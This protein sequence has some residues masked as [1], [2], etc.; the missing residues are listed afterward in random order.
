MLGKLTIFFL[1]AKLNCWFFCHKELGDPLAGPGR[2]GAGWAGTPPRGWDCLAGAGCGGRGRAGAAGRMQGEIICIGDELI[3]GQVGDQNARYAASRFT[4]LGI[5]LRAISLVRDDP[6]AIG[7]ALARGLG[8]SDFLLV[9]GGLGATDDD[10]TSAAAARALGL[11][12]GESAAMLA[13]LAAAWGPGTKPPHRGPQDGSLLPAGAES[14][15]RAARA[16]AWR[17]RWRPVYLMP[18]VPAEM[19]GLLDRAVLPRLLARQPAGG[20]VATRELR[21][22]GLGESEIQDR[23]AGL[24]DS[25]AGIGYY[26]EGVE[27]RL[28]LMG[29]GPD[30]SAAEGRVDRLAAEVGR[31]LAGLVVAED[32]ET[33]ERAVVRILAA[34]GLGLALAESCTGGLVGHRL[35]RCPAP[36]WSYCGATWSIPTRP[37]RAPGGIPRH[38]ATHGAVS[39][40]CAREMALG[41]RRAARCALGIAITGI[42]G[43]DGGSREKPGHGV[44]RPGPGRGGLDRAPPLLWRPR[45]HQGPGGRD[46]LFWLRRH[47][48]NA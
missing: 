46:A 41:A 42:A 19:R 44:L 32:G 4:S 43:P 40:Q 21:V 11:A 36:R 18:G 17:T 31:R 9:T 7:E 30:P 23:L 27:E 8:R 28:F 35:T 22:F 3:S 24:A 38:P 29:R 12:L 15:G 48:E 26:P 5:G 39:A 37:R 34:R 14:W 20:S 33:L 45:R 25:G 16:F 10:L 6:A 1:S 47:G 13:N 2:K